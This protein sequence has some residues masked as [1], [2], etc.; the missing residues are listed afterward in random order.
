MTFLESAQGGEYALQI[1]KPIHHVA[2][3]ARRGVAWRR[4]VGY[5]KSR[6]VV[7]QMGEVG[8]EKVAPI[9]STFLDILTIDDGS[10]AV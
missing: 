9:Y 2:A 4:R 7:S 5:G 10:I 1:R 3:R 6:D 8:C